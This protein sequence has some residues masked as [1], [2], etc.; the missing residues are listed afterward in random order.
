MPISTSFSSASNLLLQRINGHEVNGRDTVLGQI[1]HTNE[2]RLSFDA[3]IDFESFQKPGAF[4]LTSTSDDGHISQN[5]HG[6]IKKNPFYKDSI[7][8]TASQDYPTDSKI[9]LKLA[10]TVADKNGFTLGKPLT[11]RLR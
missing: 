8:F 4:E 10:A 9:Y 3:P 11:I 6:T 5:V 7:I 1:S 2:I